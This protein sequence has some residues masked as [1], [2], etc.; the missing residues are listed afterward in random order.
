MAELPTG[1]VTF[2]FTDVEGSTRLLQEL[3]EPYATAQDRYAAIIRSAVEA[4]SGH[5]VRIEGDSFFV[6]FSNPVHALRVAVAAQRNLAQDDWPAGASLRVRMGLHTGQAVLGGRDYI[7]IDVNRAARIAAAGHGGQVLLSEATWVLVQHEL[8]DGVTVRDLGE[9]RLKDIAH[10][11]RLFDLSIDGL[12]ADFLPPRTVDA[13][14]NNLPLQLTSFVGRAYE[15]AQAVLLTGHRLVMLTGPGGSGK[16]RL[17]LAVA[18]EVLPSFDDG[19]YFVDLAPLSDH[20]QVPSAIT[21][22]LE[23]REQPGRELIDI[24]VDGLAAKDVLLVLDNFEHLLPASG[25]AERL[26]GAAPK[27]RI[28]ATSRAPLRLYGEQELLVP[29]LAL[30]DLDDGHELDVMVQY[31]AIA[32]FAERARA[33][34]PEFSLTTK[35]AEA[36]VAIC[37]RLDGLPLAIELA[38]SRMKVLT[39]HAILSRLS[40]GHEVLTAT[41]QNLPPRQRTLRATIDWSCSLLAESERR[42]FSRLSVFRGGTYLDAVE[43]VGNPGQDLGVDTLDALSALVDHSLVR[44]TELSGAEPRFGMLETVREY[45]GELLAAEVDEAATRRRHAGYFLA[46]AH[47]GEPHLTTDGQVQWLNRFEHE[48]DNIQAAL[49]WAL[50][51]GELERGA[52]AAAATWRFWQQRGYLSVGRGWLERLISASGPHETATL[53]K[54]HLAAGSIAYYQGD[55]E[56]TD[57]QYR[58]ALAIYEVVGDRHGIAEAVYNLA[59]VPRPDASAREERSARVSDVYAIRYG[60]TVSEEVPRAG[61]GSPDTETDW[62]VGHGNIELLQGAMNQFE[63]LGDVAGVAK[64]KGNMGMFLAGIGEVQPAVPL[65]EEAIASY[66]ELHDRFHLVHALG[67][68]AQTK[69]QLGDPAAARAAIV[70]AL[71]LVDEAENAWATGPV[72]ELLSGLESAQGRHERAVRLFEAGREIQR[73]LEGALPLTAGELAGA[74][75]LGIARQAIG[76]EAVDEAVAERWS[77]SRAEAV[78]YATE[79]G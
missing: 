70:E 56:T 20:T 37:A 59:F 49:Q 8:P 69:Q 28:L 4:E 77:L 22:A 12:P 24:L 53:A 44:R 40:S 64:A 57:Q 62:R 58:K 43:A 52:D 30:P 78:A 74:D 31:E 18:S 11:E 61:G 50:E 23:M 68:Y 55:N 76:D 79:P 16:T 48:H 41:A 6:A 38:A 63:A 45:A 36:V 7:G 5:V 2:L 15:I 60:D 72:L 66:R 21:Q 73:K 34:Q 29:P 39:P 32:L 1:I 71:G 10:P 75:V 67:A 17:A 25:V 35:N 51:A 42:L 54:A 47:E 27:L 9:H 3:G 19:V 65:L 33:A 46:L 26:L 13:R 14:P